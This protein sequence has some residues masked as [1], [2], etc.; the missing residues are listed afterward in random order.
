[1][2]G[3]KYPLQGVGLSPADAVADTEQ[4]L[5]FM[6]MAASNEVA[7]IDYVRPRVAMRLPVGDRPVRLY[8]APDLPPAPAGY[9]VLHGAVGSHELWVG[10]DGSDSVTVI[11]G[12]TLKTRATVGVG[13]GH[14]L[15]AFWRD[16][17]YVTNAGDGTVSVIDRRKVSF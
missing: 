2:S 15:M 5:A 10:N 7:V 9:R 17:A 16:D 11:D 14:H 13:K 4:G 6:T 12:T 1:V 8:I 3:G